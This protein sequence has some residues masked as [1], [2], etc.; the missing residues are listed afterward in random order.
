MTATLGGLFL[1]ALLAATVLP[2]ASEPA[3][4]AAIHAG[5]APPFLAIGVATLGNTLASV[6]NWALGRFLARYR[7]RRWFPVSPARFDAAAGWYRR[8]GFWSLAFSWAPIVGDPLT[9]AAGALGTPLRV[10]VPIVLAAKF[11]RYVA[12][13][14]LAGLVLA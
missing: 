5:G 9:V 14:A 13:A 8:W 2:V 7:D 11:C 6:I 4:V 1:I 10:F 12:V 3:L